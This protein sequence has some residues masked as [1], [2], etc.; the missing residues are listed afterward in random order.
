MTQLGAMEDR[1]R[2]IGL[3]LCVC[4]E[5]GLI[6]GHAGVFP[7]GCMYRMYKV[8]GLYLPENDLH[9]WTLIQPTKPGSGLIISSLALC[10]VVDLCIT[11]PN[12]WKSAQND[13]S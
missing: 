2:G 9:D 8:R 6:H 13:H 11:R 12:G 3:T 5:K 10:V 1:I 4:T 7:L